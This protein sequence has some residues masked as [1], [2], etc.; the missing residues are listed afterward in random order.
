M[1]GLR[2]SSKTLAHDVRVLQGFTTVRNTFPF[3]V[4]VYRMDEEWFELGKRTAL[5]AMEQ[6]RACS[7]SDDWRSPDYGKIHDLDPVPNWLY[8]QEN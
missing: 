5:E 6:M 7:E 3:S 8:Q 1:R 2:V 4:E